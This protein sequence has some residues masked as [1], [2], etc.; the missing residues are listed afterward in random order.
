MSEAMPG[1]P[2]GRMGGS[3][4]LS[5]LKGG[6]KVAD[7]PP[8]RVV[9]AQVEGDVKLGVGAGESKQNQ[10]GVKRKS[11]SVYGYDPELPVLNGDWRLNPGEERAFHR[12]VFPPGNREMCP[13]A[14]RV[15]EG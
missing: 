13:F 3:A 10:G 11:Q 12:T 4:L 1:A 5:S 7:A 14:E 8:Q 6:G 2:S 15:L 9:A